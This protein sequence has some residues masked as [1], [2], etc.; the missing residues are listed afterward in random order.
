MK[1]VS[2]IACLVFLSSCGNDVPKCDDKLVIETIKLMIIP[3]TEEAL[4]VSKQELEEYDNNI[5]KL[6]EN[7]I[8][9]DDR[10]RQNLE[11]KNIITTE[12]NEELKSCGCQATMSNIE[13]GL[14]IYFQGKLL[15]NGETILY[16]VKTDSKGE[17]VVEVMS[18]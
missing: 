17:V 10:E 4:I 3:L 11:L 7:R 1:K 13:A 6:N 2:M 8:K 18:Y 14:G 16:N 12:V 5:E 9:E 15:K